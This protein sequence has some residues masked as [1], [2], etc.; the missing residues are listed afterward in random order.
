MTALPIPHPGAGDPAGPEPSSGPPPPVGP[1]G[2]DDAGDGGRRRG[3]LD[4]VA[5]AVRAAHAAGV[6]L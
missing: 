3:L 4:R 1:D 6:P 5:G 2:P